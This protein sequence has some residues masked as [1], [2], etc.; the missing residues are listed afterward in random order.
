M[1]IKLLLLR[2]NR[3]YKKGIPVIVQLRHKGKRKKIFTGL[4]S[5]PE[6]WD[7]KK[8]TPTLDNPYYQ[9][10]MTDVLKLKD[11]CVELERAN[12]TDFDKITDA[13]KLVLDED[14]Q[15]IRASF[16]AF[17]D[18]LIEKL[19]REGKDGTA[20]V[21][22]TAKV[23][24]EKYKD[25]VKFK[26]FNYNLLMNFVEE[27]KID[28]LKPNSIH[29]YL[30][31]L[32]AIY[33][34][35]VRRKGIEDTKPFAHVFDGL[36]VR[37]H[38]STK[39]YLLIEDIELLE[40]ANLTGFKDVVRDIFL[41]QFY[42]GGQDL[43]DIYYMKKSDI[44]RSRVY[45]NRSKV[46]NG[47]TFDLSVSPKVNNILNKY[48]DLDDEYMFPYRKEFEGYKTWRRRYGR[49]LIEIQNQLKI[50]I[51]PLGGNL[52]IKVA[53]HSFANI[54]KRL[55][56]EEDMLRELMGHERDDVD[57]FYKDKYPDYV[58]DH[59]QAKIINDVF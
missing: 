5:S 38:Q 47:Y 3:P 30:R 17:T 34:Q 41:L 49:Y 11:K 6:F 26:D 43:K 36:K 54:G 52:G 1:T 20:I 12:E 23:Q 58:R 10:L 44:N 56:I 21:Y 7:Y 57:N 51:K 15:E 8:E 4:H 29:N 37:S 22:N 46:V 50:E 55:G 45:F 59:A 13:I 28:G 39:K 31:T 9:H 53:R 2:T 33:N 35:A 40:K 42:L 18:T 32:R 25:D 27:K 24:F 16:F 48:S 14:E 19:K